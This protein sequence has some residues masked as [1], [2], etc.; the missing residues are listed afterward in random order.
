MGLARPSPGRRS[1]RPR[2]FI[3]LS[4]PRGYSDLS[5]QRP[6]FFGP[7]PAIH[8]QRHPGDRPRRVSDGARPRRKSAVRVSNGPMTESEILH[9]SLGSGHGRAENPPSES[10]I[11]PRPSRKSSIR[12][13]DGARPSRKS[14]IRVSD[15]RTAELKIFLPSLGRGHGRVEN[16]PSESRMAPG[17]V[18]NLPSESRMGHGR[19]ENLPSESRMGHGRVENLPSESR[20]VPGQGEDRPFESRRA[21]RPAGGRAGNAVDQDGRRCGRVEKPGSW[22]PAGILSC[23]N[24]SYG[25]ATRMFG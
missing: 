8:D 4:K 12:V 11:G 1:G 22:S 24:P 20:S 7:R 2:L 10:R 16:L 6:S 23:G 15:G 18:E 19:V 13:S 3:E 21:S 17:R 25:T 14:S 5:G 9:P